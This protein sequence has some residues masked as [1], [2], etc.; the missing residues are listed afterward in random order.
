M[1]GVEVTDWIFV[2]LSTSIYLC[3][4]ASAHCRDDLGDLQSQDVS[5][6]KLA[7]LCPFRAWARWS[8]TSFLIHPSWRCLVKSSLMSM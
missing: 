1:N 7:L 4:G 2:C 3:T 5:V 6:T 8:V